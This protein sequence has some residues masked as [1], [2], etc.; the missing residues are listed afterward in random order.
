MTSRPAAA[1]SVR[2]AIAFGPGVQC[3]IE[4]STSTND[5]VK[6]SVVVVGRR[7]YNVNGVHTFEKLP[8]T[9]AQSLN[10]A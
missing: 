5:I 6:P 10:V 3:L 7:Q 2:N 8:V 1:A 9:S 4:N